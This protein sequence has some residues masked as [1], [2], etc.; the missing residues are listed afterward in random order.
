[1]GL[2]SLLFGIQKIQNE[3]D[4][5][6]QLNFPKFSMYFM[7]ICDQILYISL[8]FHRKCCNSIEVWRWW[9]SSDALSRAWGIN[10]IVW[11]KYYQLNN[12]HR[13]HLA[14][15]LWQASRCW[16]RSRMTRL[17]Y[18]YLMHTCI[19]HKE[20]WHSSLPQV[21]S[22]DTKRSLS[23]MIQSS[24]K[25]IAHHAFAII[26]AYMTLRVI[27][28]LLVLVSCSILKIFCSHC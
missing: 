17:W 13:Y 5:D 7:C 24:R 21:Q 3:H 27:A 9:A 1:M 15:W 18:N 26:P 19:V 2:F 28:Y 16:S 14:C 6:F 22:R 8:E 25:L 23:L 4:I 11:T 10:M 12:S 20:C